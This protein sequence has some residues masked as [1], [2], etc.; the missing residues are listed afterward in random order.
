MIISPA[1]HGKKPRAIILFL[2]PDFESGYKPTPLYTRAEYNLR[3]LL[4]FAA[5]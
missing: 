2:V 5:L 3:T 4:N 1:T